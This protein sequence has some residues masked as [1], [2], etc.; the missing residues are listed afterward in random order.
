M[1]LTRSTCAGLWQWRGPGWCQCPSEAA[2]DIRATRW[3]RQYQRDRWLPT[4]LACA[5]VA[6]ALFAVFA[7]AMAIT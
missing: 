6:C 5:T 3:Q 2:H 4:A 7:R 1:R